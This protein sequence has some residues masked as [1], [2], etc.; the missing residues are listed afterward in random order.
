VKVAE[1][2]LDFESVK[3]SF[4]VSSEFRSENTDTML[5]QDVLQLKRGLW[6]GYVSTCLLQDALPAHEES[7]QGLDWA[8]GHGDMELPLPPTVD[9]QMS[10]KRRSESEL[11]RRQA[12]KARTKA[13]NGQ[14]TTDA[15]KVHSCPHPACSNHSCVK[16]DF[17][18]LFS[19]L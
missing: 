9:L 16:M 15:E 13:Q 3:Y 17:Q 1:D 19:H 6:H 11:L 12:K 2:F 4:V 5:L 7:T 18:G 8:M 14:I 10:R